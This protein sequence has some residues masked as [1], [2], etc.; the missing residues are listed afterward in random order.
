ME[1]QFRSHH[2]LQH[3]SH[4]ISHYQRIESCSRRCNSRYL[5]KFQHSPSIAPS[6]ISPYR[7]HT[8]HA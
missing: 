5:A 2:P 3:P 8:A 7:T 6:R 1:Q 4:T